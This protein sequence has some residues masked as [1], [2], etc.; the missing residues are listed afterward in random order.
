MADFLFGALLFAAIVIGWLLGKWERRKPPP[1][2]PP[3]GPSKEYFRGVNLLLNQQQDEA[4]EVLLEALDVNA[5]TIDTYLVMGALFRRRGQVDRAIRIHQNLLARPA[6]E[7]SQIVTAKLEL[8]NDYLKAGVLDRSE[9][10]LKQLVAEDVEPVPQCLEKLL[11]IYEQERG[12]SSAVDTAL[13]LNQHEGFDC[14]VR[15][16]QYY[17]ELALVEIQSENFLQARG[18]LTSALKHDERCVRANLILGELEN[19]QGNYKAAVNALLNVPK[20]SPEFVSEI[21]AP[22][23]VSYEGLNDIDGYSAAL[24]NILDAAPSM[25]AVT[26]L[27]DQIAAQKGSDE[28]AF[29]IRQFLQKRPSVRG[30]DKLLEYQT[31]QDTPSDDLDSQLSKTVTEALIADKPTFRCGSCGYEGRLLHWHCPSCKKWSTVAPILGLEG[32]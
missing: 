4:M 27:A 7:A 21:L 23:R 12:W 10:L 13:Q 14:S 16:A 22:L 26:A 32:D 8:A 31:G 9:R 29:I 20:Q 15:L 5:D 3:K 24:F 18:H 1:P 30:L 11:S 2:A 25:A 19:S 6:L 17:C 28:G